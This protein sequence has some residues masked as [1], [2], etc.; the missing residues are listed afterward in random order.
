MD[1]TLS[2]VFSFA[3]HSPSTEENKINALMHESAVSATT[4]VMR[5][6]LFSVLWIQST[7]GEG[8]DTHQS[9]SS[10]YPH[11]DRILVSTMKTYKHPDVNFSRLYN[12]EVPWRSKQKFYQSEGY[13]RRPRWLQ[14]RL[15][16]FHHAYRT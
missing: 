15:D 7:N 4:L 1:T 13:M 2:F 9:P 6:L 16:S 10:L 3:E 12:F 8:I 11:F 5:C 14:S